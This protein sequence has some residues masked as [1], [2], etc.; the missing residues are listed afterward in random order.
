MEG[1][2]KRLGRYTL[3]AE[4]ASGGMATVYLGRLEGEAGFRRPVAVKALHPAYAKDPAFVAMLLDEARIVSHIAHPNVVQVLDVVAEAGDLALVMEHV[5]GASLSVLLRSKKAPSH[6]IAV[7]IALDA[8][9]GLHAAHVALDAE[10]RQL[11]IVHRDVSPQ[12]LIVGFDGI[13]RVLDFGIAKALGRSTNTDAGT[14]KGKLGYMSP[15]QVLGKTVN[16]STDT[17]A[18]G[19]VLWELLAGRRLFVAVTQAELAQRVH[20]GLTPDEVT[21]PGVPGPVLEVLRK[22][23]ARAPGDRFATAQDFAD[24]LEQAAPRARSKEVGEWV[25]TAAPPEASAVRAA[26][27]APNSAATVNDL[28]T[29]SAILVGKEGAE[30]SPAPAPRRWPFAVL[31]ALA[32]AAA[33]VWLQ[34]APVM[35]TVT[36][37]VIDSGVQPLSA[38]VEPVVPVPAPVPLAPEP[39][40][41]AGAL[42]V[43]APRPPSKRPAKKAT[44][45]VDCA[46]PWELDASGNRIFK[47]ACLK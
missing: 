25:A 44:A 17:Y 46:V 31:A 14:I 6:P 9:R 33:V 10:H 21:L 32:V 12:N 19:I 4:I 47:R 41:D 42:P 23:L 38:L 26:L 28:Q 45:E 13:C 5:R 15:E 40:L 11:E 20:D 43:I 24:A 22:A 29:A 34:R 39:P 30:P 1:A 18:M 2:P 35:N 16:A 36:S 8:L 7:S 37:E 27:A 3:L